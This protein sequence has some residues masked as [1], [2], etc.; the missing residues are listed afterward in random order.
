MLHCQ[1]QWGV[2]GGSVDASRK[3]HTCSVRLM[4]VALMQARRCVG[5]CGVM[6]VMVALMQGG[7]SRA[8]EWDC[9]K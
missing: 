3:L 6:F 2:Y 8:V 7:T 9:N 5:R 1:T 4:A